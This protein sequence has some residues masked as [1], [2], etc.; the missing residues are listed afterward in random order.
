MTRRQQPQGHAYDPRCIACTDRVRL[1]AWL[2]DRRALAGAYAAKVREIRAAAEEAR[3]ALLAVH[4]DTPDE[5]RTFA[6]RQQE[7]IGMC[8]MANV[9]AERAIEIHDRADRV[10]AAHP[11]PAGDAAHQDAL[12]DLT[13]GAA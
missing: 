5:W 8:A 1:T 12:F 3:K 4:P 13:G 2:A 10:E 6:D 7:H 9:W 11:A